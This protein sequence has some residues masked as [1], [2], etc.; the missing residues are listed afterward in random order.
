MTRILCVSSATKFN[1]FLNGCFEQ[2]KSTYIILAENCPDASIILASGE[3]DIIII[4][5]PVN[6]TDGAEFAVGAAKQQKGAVVLLL[7]NEINSNDINEKINDH[8]I[9]MITK[10]INKAS[11]LSIIKIFTGSGLK[12][13]TLESEN[14]RLREK[15]FEVRIVDR[16]KLILIKVLGL[17]E[18][19]AHKLIEK[20]AMDMRITKKK[21]AENII[22]TY[23]S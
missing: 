23:D 16:A 4:N 3:F 12:A 9:F 5:T 20:Q 8:N 18:N 10:P 22:K 14:I 21:V 13:G 7:I 1:D 15:L 17:T 11:F 2:D 6:G 19:E